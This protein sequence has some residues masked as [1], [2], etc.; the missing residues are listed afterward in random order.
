MAKMDF[1]K[2][3][4]IKKK[5]ITQNISI[6]TGIKIQSLFWL[7]SVKNDMQIALLIIEIDNT[8][9]VNLLINKKLVLDHIL[10]EYIR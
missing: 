8:K 7:L 1:G 5:L 9:M 6:Y 2:M 10:Y 3:E 4:K